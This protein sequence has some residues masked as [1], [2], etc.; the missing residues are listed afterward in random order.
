MEC[1]SCTSPA[2]HVSQM[3]QTFSSNISAWKC[4]SGENYISSTFNKPIR[5]PY[6]AFFIN[7]H[8]FSKNKSNRSGK[9]SCTYIFSPIKLGQTV[10]QKGNRSDLLCSLYN[11]VTARPAQKS[12]CT[13]TFLMRSDGPQHMV[14]KL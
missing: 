13:L 8:S 7:S 2:A 4:F 1:V 10:F 11:K 9:V 14:Q 12:D 5:G 3:W 6:N